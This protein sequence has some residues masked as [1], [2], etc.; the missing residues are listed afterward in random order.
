MPFEANRLQIFIRVMMIPNTAV[1]MCGQEGFNHSFGDKDQTH[2]Q[3][4]Q[5]KHII[6]VIV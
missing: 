4:N 2:R 6:A 3:R 5:Y 1:P